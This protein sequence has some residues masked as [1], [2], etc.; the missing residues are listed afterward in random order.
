MILS[1]LTASA[2]VER[3]FEA[4]VVFASWLLI[5]ISAVSAAALDWKSTTNATVALPAEMVALTASGATPA[6][7]ATFWRITLSTCLVNSLTEA[8]MVTSIVRVYEAGG[9]DSGGA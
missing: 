8:D 4:A 2:V 3:N 1:T 9:G 6:S 5:D 7:A